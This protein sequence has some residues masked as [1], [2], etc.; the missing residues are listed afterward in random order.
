[1]TFW[2]QR[3]PRP[4]VTITGGPDNSTNAWAIRYV[5]ERWTGLQFTFG[6]SDPSTFEQ[7][8]SWS[9][10]D[11]L[12]WSE[13]STDPRALVTALNFQSTTSQHVLYARCRNRWGSISA[14]VARQFT[15]TVPNFDDPNYPRRTLILNNNV[16][17]TASPV[18]T[19]D[20]NQVKAFFRELMDS[21]GRSGTYD[22]WSTQSSSGAFPSRTAM[23][24]YSAVIL[25]SEHRLSNLG[26]AG[27]RYIV[28]NGTKQPLLENYLNVGG[29]MVY[30]TAPDVDR[31]WSEYS[32]W[33]ERIWHT[34]PLRTPAPGGSA[35]RDFT[36]ATGRLGYPSLNLD[37]AKIHPDSTATPGGP[38]ALRLMMLHPPRGFGES[39]Y[40][41]NSGTAQPGFAN[42]PLGVRYLAP[43]P[44][45]PARSTY[46][47]VSFGFPLYYME[48]SGAIGA[49]RKAFT[50]INE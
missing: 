14:T 33:S 38:R 39:I 37:P 12:H 36:G 25:L 15:A 21:L 5:T 13:W 26:L 47:V 34:Q 49:L 40:L 27:L 22:I 46:S 17:L 32:R 3:A 29:K 41:Y 18:L 1:V 19:P 7:Q 35:E 4:I 44:V 9:V 31:V 2:T 48:K 30:S 8:F 50:D 24:N 45:P 11:T 20:T 43:P 10:D 23:G 28:E 42:G 6:F 16:K